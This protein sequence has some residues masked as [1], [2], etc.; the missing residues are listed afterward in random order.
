MRLYHCDKLVLRAS[1]NPESLLSGITTNT[2]DAPQTAFIDVFGK[3]VV[4]ADQIRIRVKGTIEG[5]DVLLVI[6]RQFFQRLKKHIHQYVLLCD[7]KLTEEHWFVYWNLDQDYEAGD[8]E[9]V[10]P[11]KAG[12]LVLSPDDLACS[13]SEEDFVRFRLKNNIPLQGKDFDQEMAL[14]VGDW[15]VSFAK[16][17]FLGQEVVARVKSRS[18]P[19]K[20][21]IV[22]NDIQC[23]SEQKKQMTSVSLNQS[24][25]VKQG[26]LFVGNE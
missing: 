4:M 11:Q 16:G 20:K 1:P 19:P 13:V 25:G 9:H 6:E 3:I 17:C 8:D 2:L 7:T 18:K 10:I 23:T 5:G 15:F 14:N 24:T 26:F 21:L 22:I 12:Q